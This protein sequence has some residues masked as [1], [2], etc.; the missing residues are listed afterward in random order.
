MIAMTDFQQIVQLRNE[1][2]TQEEIANRLGISRRSVIRYLKDG[3]IP[4]YKRDTTANKPDPMKGF[5]DLAKQKL[6]SA[7]VILLNDLFIYLS[8][9]GYQGSERTLRR[10]TLALRNAMTKKEVYFQRKLIPG[11]VMEGDF[12][13]LYVSIENTRRK[14]YLWVTTLPY[15]NT[16]FATPYYHCTFECFANGSVDAFNEFNGIAKTYRLDNMSPAVSKILSGKDRI[17]TSRYKQLQDHYGFEQDF[18]NP[19]KGNEKGNVESNNRHLK[20]KIASRIASNKLEFSSLEAFKTF[21]WDL[22]REHNNLTQVDS[23]LQ[24]EPLKVLPDNPFQCFRTEVVTINK[25]AL[26]TLNKTGH[27]YSVPSQYIGLRLELRLYPNHLTLLHE[28]AVIAEHTRIYGPK[29]RISILP[30]HVIKGLAK[31]PGAMKDWKYRHVLFDR[32]SWLMFYNQVITN[33]GRDKDYLNC[34]KLI[35][36]HGRELVTLAMELA[37]ENDEQLS[38]KTLEKII[39]NEMDN[40][41]EIKPLNP[42]LHHYDQLLQGGNYGKQFTSES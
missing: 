25:Y 5:Y 36:T 1:G 11:Q 14:V 34:L 12:T 40:V 19:A 39:T 26:F 35:T 2:N 17:V 37:V 16:L 29:G 42:S 21:V 4:V 18:C 6:E 15:S 30:E 38:A 10:K 13:E 32:P 7:P 3:K 9:H 20:C 28:G 22:C 41:H 27:M 23:K 24:E 33:G 31:K 8:Q